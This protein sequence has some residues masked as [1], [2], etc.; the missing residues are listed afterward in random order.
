MQKRRAR[1]RSR[2]P[3]VARDPVQ[4]YL[5]DTDIFL[6]DAIE[7]LQTSDTQKPSSEAITEFRIKKIENLID[8]STFRNN[9]EHDYFKALYEL[10]K[11]PMR[12]TAYRY[13]ATI[14]NE[15]PPGCLLHSVIAG[16]LSLV[17]E[18]T[19]AIRNVLSPTIYFAFK[20]KKFIWDATAEFINTADFNSS[21]VKIAT[22]FTCLVLALT[23]HYEKLDDVVRITQ[24]ILSSIKTGTL[25]GQKVLGMIAFW[26]GIPLHQMANAA[27]WTRNLTQKEDYALK[28]AAFVM[29]MVETEWFK[30]YDTRF[31]YD[32]MLRSLF[33]SHGNGD[34]TRTQ[35]VLKEAFKTPLGPIMLFKWYIQPLLFFVD[36]VQKM[37]QGLSPYVKPITKIDMALLLLTFLSLYFTEMSKGSI[38]SSV[39]SMTK[40]LLKAYRQQSSLMF[41]SRSHNQRIQAEKRF[42][43]F[44]NSSEY[45]PLPAG[46]L[47]EEVE[48]MWRSGNLKKILEKQEK[49]HLIFKDRFDSFLAAI[50]ATEI[51]DEIELNEKINEDEIRMQDAEDLHNNISNLNGE[52]V[53]KIALI[54]AKCRACHISPLAI[55]NGNHAMYIFPVQ[56]TQ[57]GPTPHL[58]ENGQ[59]T[60]FGQRIMTKNKIIHG[61]SRTVKSVIPMLWSQLCR[62]TYTRNVPENN[63]ACKLVT[64]A[65]DPDVLLSGVEF[66][67]VVAKYGAPALYSGAGMLVGAALA[68]T[69]KA[70]R[71]YKSGISLFES[72]LVKTYRHRVPNDVDCE[73]GGR[74]NIKEV[75]FENKE[76]QL[77]ILGRASWFLSP[78][79]YVKS[80]NQ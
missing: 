42:L 28:L 60:P 59:A 15:L 52:L 24:A 66:G 30:S 65:Y 35:Y 23:W 41:F 27:L 17:A 21:N 61:E 1:S 31:G 2:P 78:L 40:I 73:K 4:K 43:Q 22:V 44:Y 6:E 53:K 49:P 79:T 9:V 71:D 63:Y 16:S 50:G 76:L 67:D 69:A 20:N 25:L 77:D 74:G 45:Q 32:N 26:A 19:T 64:Y 11:K 51:Y 33:L 12:R 39:T 46:L 70:Y 7:E 62:K 55:G 29:M 18:P 14:N 3:G 48:N 5:F 47:P 8:L 75:D 34:L 13:W 10:R 58:Y 54:D 37:M 72:G 56:P 80:Q 68:M 38:R 36:S 57:Y